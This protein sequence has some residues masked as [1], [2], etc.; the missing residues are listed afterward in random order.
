MK[1][2][3]G[4]SATEWVVLLT[5]L[6]IGILIV[7]PV[8]VSHAEKTARQASRNNL[9]QWGIALNL[10]LIEH[11]NELPHPGSNNPSPD[12]ELAWY[13]AL[14]LYL[15]QPPLTEIES[16]PQ[17]LKQLWTNPSAPEQPLAQN[18]RY[19][20]YYGMNLWLKP[21][22]ENPL[23]IYDI[24]DPT[25]T[26]FMTE[27]YTNS[28]HA[29]PDRVDYRFGKPLPSGEAIAHVLFC[30]GHVEPVTKTQ[31]SDNPDAYNPQGKITFPT[32]VPY[33]NAPKPSQ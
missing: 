25:A 10:Y 12:E 9:L 16:N 31:L 7:V 23:R 5:L 4:F 20:F 14:P 13:N 28:P 1:R 17:A 27:I 30:D 3:S 33:Y 24:E 18:N 11:R 6:V 22:G 29:L 15:S 32:W 21:A 19:F 26:V 2:E 8:Y